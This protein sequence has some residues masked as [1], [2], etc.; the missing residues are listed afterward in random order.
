MEAFLQLVGSAGLPTSFIGLMLF[1][2]FTVRKQEA[3]VRAEQIATIERLRADVVELEAAKDKAEAI[4]E[5][6]RG[7]MLDKDREIARLVGK[8][9]RLGSDDS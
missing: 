5:R 4:A 6:L 8:L 7:D 9:F 1:L 2:Y 3:T